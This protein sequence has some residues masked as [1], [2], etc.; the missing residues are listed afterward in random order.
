M[1][2]YIREGKASIFSEGINSPLRGF[3]ELCV[4]RK[5]HV[6]LSYFLTSLCSKL[7]WRHAYVHTCL[8]LSYSSEFRVLG[9]GL[10]LKQAIIRTCSRIICCLCWLGFL[11]TSVGILS[12]W[13]MR[14]EACGVTYLLRIFWSC[15]A[16]KS[17]SKTIVLFELKWLFVLFSILC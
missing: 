13:E 16:V 11:F 12:G 10:M 6:S 2:D 15:Y 4:C 3:F 5:I 7:M 14:N 9:C 1:T 17:N 8:S